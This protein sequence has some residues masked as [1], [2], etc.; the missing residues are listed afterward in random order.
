MYKNKKEIGLL[1][2]LKNE[3][4]RAVI[5]K[6]ILIIIFFSDIYFLVYTVFCRLPNIQLYK[7]DYDY[8]FYVILDRFE[9]WI[10][11]IRTSNIFTMFS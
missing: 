11:L 10:E 9:I 4:G 7:K 1:I 3:L 6:R 2:I 5:G 8:F